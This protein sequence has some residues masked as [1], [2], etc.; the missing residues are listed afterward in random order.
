MDL[1]FEI[2]KYASI[3]LEYVWHNFFKNFIFELQFLRILSE[4]EGNPNLG[5]IMR[6]FLPPKVEIFVD[7]LEYY[8]Y[9]VATNLYSEIPFRAGINWIFYKYK[10][11]WRNN[12]L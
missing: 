5:Q 2:H 10:V 4:P 11:T 8:F 9:L 3:L 7:N 1:K 12:H 6:N